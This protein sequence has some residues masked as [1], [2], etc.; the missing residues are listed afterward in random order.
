MTYASWPPKIDGGRQRYRHQAGILAGEE[1]AQKVRICL[2]YDGHPRAPLER[3]RK[4]AASQHQRLLAKRAVR[5]HGRE[6][7]PA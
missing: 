4:Q 6:F 2:R 3:K 7:A 1:E 5:K